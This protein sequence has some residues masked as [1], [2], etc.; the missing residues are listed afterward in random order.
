MLTGRTRSP[1]STAGEVR[2][3]A[4]PRGRQPGDTPRLPRSGSA[5]PAGALWAF[6]GLLADRVRA[7]GPDDPH[8][9]NTHK[10]WLAGLEDSNSSVG[11]RQSWAFRIPVFSMALDVIC[12]GVRAEGMPI[13]G[14]IDAV[15]L[16]TEEVPSASLAESNFRVTPDVS[17]S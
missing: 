15:T 7:P 13:F 16:V 8:A 3:S 4:A 17:L 9:L 12:N 10:N 5:S 11:S 14:H 2:F 1:V 6:E